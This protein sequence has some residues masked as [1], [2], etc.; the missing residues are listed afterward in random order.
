MGIGAV[1]TAQ[2]SAV[3]TLAP[4][5]LRGSAFGLLATV[6]SLGNLAAS[7]VAGILCIVLSPIVA[8]AYLTAWMLLALVGLSCGC[9]GSTPR[10]GAWHRPGSR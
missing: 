9:G 4:K 7:T 1:E 2:H 8:F 3:A 6:Q 10:Y 5:D